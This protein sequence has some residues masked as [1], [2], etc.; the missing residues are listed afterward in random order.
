MLSFRLNPALDVVGLARTYAQD[1]I[2]QIEDMFDPQTADAMEVAMRGLPW[3]LLCQNERGES[4]LLSREELVAMSKEERARF[5]GGIR[6][7]AAANLGY[8]YFAYPMIDALLAGREPGHPI[9][10]LTEFLNSAP[11][12]EFARTLIGCPGLTKIDG[13]ATNYQRGHYLTRHIDDGA[14]KERRAA[15]TLGFTRKWEPDWGGLLLFLDEKNNVRRGFLPRFNVLTVFDGLMLHTVTQ[16]SG[17]APAARLS[18][19]GWFRDDPL[20]AR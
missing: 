10:A 14:R 16:V 15:Y 6:E 18:V 4:I 19:A 7:R 11:F 17:F 3:R 8:T 1:K 12:L 2:V 20:P 13:H 9:H 5:E